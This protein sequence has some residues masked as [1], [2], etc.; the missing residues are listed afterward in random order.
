MSSAGVFNNPAISNL[1]PYLYSGN[2]PTVIKTVFTLNLRVLSPITGSLEITPVRTTSRFESLSSLNDGPESAI[3]DCASWCRQIPK[4][5]NK[6]QNPITANFLPA[7]LETDLPRSSLEAMVWGGFPSG[8]DDREIVK[9]E[10]K[11]V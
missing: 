8:W 5:K 10:L 6:I 3:L 1:S 11:K 2:L 9:E 4:T 7:P